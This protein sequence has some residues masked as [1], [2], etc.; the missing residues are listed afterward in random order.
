MFSFMSVVKLKEGM[1]LR[2]VV[3]F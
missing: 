2:I 1:V 3:V